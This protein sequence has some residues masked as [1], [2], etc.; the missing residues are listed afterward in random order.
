MDAPVSGG[1]GG[2]AAGTLTIMIG[3]NAEIV[4]NCKPL[5][6]LYAHNVFHFGETGTGMAAKL[7][8]QALVG[9]HAQAACEALLMAER[10]NI[11]GTNILLEMLQTSWGQSKLLELTFA[12][13]IK[14]EKSTWE[15]VQNS[16]APLRNL[17]K[18][19]SCISKDVNAIDIKN[20]LST[21]LP[22]TERTHASIGA[23][24]QKGLANDAFVSLL[25]ILRTDS[26]S[27]L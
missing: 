15:I 12:D 19:F 14:A 11:K 3:G 10:F 4:T 25:Q 22:L 2:A 1:P 27:T 26:S 18:D 9:V 23:A 5:L 6:S 7:I 16:G 21:Q 13:Y 20:Q 17:E 24:C 8:N